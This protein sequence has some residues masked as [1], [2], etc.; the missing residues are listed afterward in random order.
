[1]G[2]PMNY[3]VPNFGV[4]SDIRDTQASIATTEFNMGHKLKFPPGDK[5]HR[6]KAKE[7]LYDF[8]QK[9]DADIRTT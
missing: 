1:M 4:D 6:N 2:Y 9:I 8:D 3:F 7:T 5:R